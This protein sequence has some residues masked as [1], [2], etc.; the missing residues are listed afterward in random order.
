MDYTNY[1]NCI[2]SNI[3]FNTEWSGY[4]TKTGT[5]KLFKSKEKS[6]ANNANKLITWHSHYAKKDNI[7]SY[8]DLLALLSA[9]KTKI[10]L[11][12][13]KKGYILIQKIRKPKDA[14]FLYKKNEWRRL[15]K[16]V[17]RVYGFKIKIKF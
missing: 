6:V 2:R 5:L 9:N 7:P 4:I 10:H 12:I 17:Y 8:Q 3:T 14:I 1:A 11:L 15:W 16:I 13:L